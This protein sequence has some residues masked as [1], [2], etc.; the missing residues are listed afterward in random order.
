MARYRLLQDAFMAARPGDIH[1]RID[2]GAEVVLADEDFGLGPHFEPLDD[3]ARKARAEYDRRRPG[4]TLDPTSR[5]PLGR[6][7]LAMLTP[8]QS[9]MQHFDKLLAGVT[10]A[11]PG[12]NGEVA[13]LREQ[14]DSLQKQIAA[15]VRRER[16]KV[17]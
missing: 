6:D 16:A 11:A 1:R 2:A 5:L 4:A 9:L 8:E 12:A 10:A 3:A 15:L 7:P 13:A 14:V 17:E